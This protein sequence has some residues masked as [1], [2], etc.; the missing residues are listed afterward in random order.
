MNEII[1]I[2]LVTTTSTLILVAIGVIFHYIAV[3]IDWILNIIKSQINKLFKNAK[4]IESFQCA[5]GEIH[6][7][8]RFINQSYF[9]I[10][11]FCTAKN[12]I[13]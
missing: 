6:K 11:N 1:G 4:E 3:F 10:C 8:K 9:Y 12:F 7:G 13:Q 5:C 2:L